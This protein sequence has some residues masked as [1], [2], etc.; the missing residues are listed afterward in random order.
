[1]M[2][3]IAAQLEGYRSLMDKSIKIT[4]ESQELNPQEL[5][6]IGIIKALKILI[7][8]IDIR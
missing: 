8:I 4:F 5:L 1:M 7:V 6:G 2:I 3:I